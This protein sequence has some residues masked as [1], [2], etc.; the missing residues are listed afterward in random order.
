MS[1]AVLTAP[2]LLRSLVPQVRR[3]HGWRGVVRLVV[4]PRALLRDH[5][6]EQRHLRLVR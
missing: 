1:T 4:A 2:G 3:R 6:A 5:P